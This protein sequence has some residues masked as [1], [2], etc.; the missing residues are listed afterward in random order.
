MPQ[1][2]AF[3]VLG[4][5]NIDPDADGLST[6]AEQLVSKS[7]PTN[8]N[9][10]R[11]I[12][13]GVISNQNPSAWFRLNDSSLTN[14]VGGAGL[15]NEGS[16]WEPDVFVNGNS[17][18]SFPS[19]SD[20]ER[21]IAED[22]I[23][24]GDGTKQGSMSL[25]FRSL[26]GGMPTTR[27][28]VF[29]QKGTNNSNTVYDGTEFSVFIEED[30]PPASPPPANPGSLNMQIGGNMVELLSTNAMVFGAWY[31]L[32]ITW[33]ETN[34]VAPEVTWYLGR[35]GGT[36]T[37]GTINLTNSAVVGN[38]NVV[39]LGNRAGQNRSLRRSG[40]N[41]ALDEI[42]FW[43]R[44]LASTEVNVQFYMLNSILHGPS[45]YFDLTR[46][47]LML[48]VDKVNQL[49]PTNAPLE[50]STGWLNSGFRYVDPMTCTQKYFYRGTGGTMVF[51]APWNGAVDGTG[52]RSEL[53][54][55]KADGNEDN[56]TL[57]GTNT[58][59][60]TCAVN[61]AGTNGANKVIIG[62][63]YCKSA[64][65]PTFTVNYNFPQLKQ[66]SVTYKFNPDGSGTPPDNNLTLATNVN[67]L[68]LIQYKVQLLDNGT[69]VKIHGEASVNG[70]PQPPPTDVNLTLN[71]ASPWH[72]NTFYFKAG[73]YYPNNPTSG[74]AKVTF[75]S[76][77][78]TRQP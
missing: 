16:A 57:A 17:A 19:A 25:L 35:P 6:A 70:V 14:S 78:G 64:N 71:P 4:D 73:C 72:T 31:Y 1:T 27:R 18:F 13:E 55:T 38:T 75:S 28:F 3:F 69:T 54:G 22:V 2:N 53:R 49:G 34:D 60:A 62:Q 30:L 47:E 41:G 52:P 65:V 63:I 50:I 51:E 59:E 9:C 10:P 24:G 8:A 74:T 58:L 43:N 67:L 23:N 46:W 68:D 11:P 7:N 76:L 15:T 37:S 32:A 44:E 36:L 61:I 12:Y 20:N 48:P 26:T 77:T 66:V 29:S 33:N 5:A 39:H 45:T 56:W 21:L 40:N 42:A